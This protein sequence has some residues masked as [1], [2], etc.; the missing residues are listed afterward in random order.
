[1][2][3]E[4]V[5]DF[6][7]IT[8]SEDA[9][10]SKLFLEMAGGNL[11]T[12]ISLFFE[13]GGSSLLK[14]QNQGSTSA[15]ANGA[16]RSGEDGGL[17]TDADFAKR[18]QNEAYQDPQP[19]DTGYV[20]PPDEARHE[21]LTETNTFSTTFSGGGGVYAPLLRNSRDMFDNSRPEGIFNQRFETLDSDGDDDPDI[22]IPDDE[23]EVFEYIEE[24]VIEIDDDGE[25]REFTKVVRKPK[26]ISKEQ[27]LALL[28]K[29]PFDM[30]SKLGLDGAKSKAIERKKWI[31]IN[32][33]DSGIFQCQALNRDLWSSKDLKK[34]LRKNFIFLQ[35]QFES[36]SAQQ[37]NQFYGIQDKDDLPHIAILDPMTGER[38]KQWNRTVPKI[39]AFINEITEF[40]AFFSLDPTTANPVVTEPIP[41]LDPTILTE[42]QQMEL[43]IRQSMGLPISQP[44]IEVPKEFNPLIQESSVLDAQGEGEEDDDL[45]NT[46]SAVPHTEPPNKPGITTRIQIRIGDGRR[47]VRRFNTTEDTVRIIYEFIKSEVEGFDICRFKLTNHQREDI[48]EKLAS[49]IEDAGLK[50]SSLL[51]TQEEEDE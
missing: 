44:D 51:L 27:R 10:L 18:L 24:P 22:S 12:A 16:N 25:I 1:M 32:I 13:H 6:M 38:L 20:R 15:D 43:A 48:I 7:A 29:P 8:S 47:I 4:Q 33:Q 21:T 5:T 28:F 45:F 31:M 35:Y 42:E 41:K 36:R 19:G 50:N 17:E 37:Y 26:Q 40:L 3:D 11:E 46:I 9:D 30:I 34:L 23:D 2:A 49:T 39:D 14:S